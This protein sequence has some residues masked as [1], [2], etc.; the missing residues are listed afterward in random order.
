M[1]FRESQELEDSAVKFQDPGV[2]ARRGL[3][4]RNESPAPARMRVPPPRPSDRV[5]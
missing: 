4:K 2:D 1:K 5:G 3:P